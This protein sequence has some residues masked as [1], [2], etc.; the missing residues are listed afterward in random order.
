[1]S[2]IKKPW[3]KYSLG[4][5]I[6]GLFVWQIVGLSMGS[7]GSAPDFT[8][9]NQ[10]GKR[11]SLSDYQ[12]KVVILDFWATWC[13]PCKAEIPGFVKLYN[14]YQD[15]DLAIIGVS[16][17]Q[18]GWSDVKPFIR[19]YQMTYPVVMGNMDVVDAYGGIRSIPTTFV[20]DKDGAIQKK[21]I[22]YRPEDVF[23]QD[24]LSL[25]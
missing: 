7:S 11:V 24:Y 23:E 12:G 19:N 18:T 22:G 15:Q 13:P 2:F 9:V 17:D 6:A 21:Y 14:K 8:L 1:M 3:V 16:L 10:D 20:L 5:L 25:R 4:A